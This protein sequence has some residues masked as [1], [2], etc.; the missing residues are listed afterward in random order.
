MTER[1]FQRSAVDER[2]EELLAVE[3]R[4]AQA[5]HK[6]AHGDFAVLDLRFQV[7]HVQGIGAGDITLKDLAVGRLNHGL[8]FQRRQARLHGEL[9]ATLGGVEVDLGQLQALLIR[10]RTLAQLVGGRGRF[11]LGQQH[12]KVLLDDFGGFRIATEIAP[13]RSPHPINGHDGGGGGTGGFNNFAQTAHVDGNDVGVAGHDRVGHIAQEP[14]Q[15]TQR[16]L[17]VAWPVAGHVNR[18]EP[19]GNRATAGGVEKAQQAIEQAVA[20]A[21]HIGHGAQG[22]PLTD[23]LDDPSRPSRHRFSGLFQK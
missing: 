8:L 9:R 6:F 11:E 21:F 17:H 13:C 23:R 1:Q 18:T 19:S 15:V 7:R 4:F 5:T 22:H 12:I 14:A 20:L 10:G 16:L 3:G 2:L